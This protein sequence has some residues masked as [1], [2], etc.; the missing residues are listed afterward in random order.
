VESMCITHRWGIVGVGTAKCV[1]WGSSSPSSTPFIASFKEGPIDSSGPPPRSK[2]RPPEGLTRYKVP[3][4]V[5]GNGKSFK[6]EG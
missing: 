3:S 4:K 1:P 5:S 6:T 2:F